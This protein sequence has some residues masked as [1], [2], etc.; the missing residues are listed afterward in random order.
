MSV[1]YLTDKSQICLSQRVNI[2]GA[3][4]WHMGMAAKFD[5]S[6]SIQLLQNTIDYLTCKGS[7][8]LDFTDDEKEFMKELFEA[9]WWGGKYLGYKEAATLANHY[10]NGGGHS[11]KLPSDMYSSS[12]IVKDVCLGIK[13][14][15]KE[16]YDKKKPY[17][18]IR[19]NDA[20]FLTSKFASS[21]LRGRRNANT[22][23]YLLPEGA[24]LTEQKNK[25]LK[26]ADHR[27]ILQASTI[28]S[29]QKFITTW[30]VD[31]VYDFEPFSKGDITHL[32]LA[33][34]LT[35][36]LPDGLSQYLTKI[37]VAKSFKHYSEWV[38][39]WI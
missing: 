35:L 37:E 29:A 13:T 11:I 30:R 38:E 39:N 34:N 4:L 32:E 12:I 17:Q 18:I 2:P 10:V 15:I 1:D 31:S 21:L 19:S 3:P 24:L 16:L 8:G 9:M 22:L 36:K 7:A 27:F 20:A 26:N 5:K 6:E 23:G 14:F 25:R 28:K 33:P